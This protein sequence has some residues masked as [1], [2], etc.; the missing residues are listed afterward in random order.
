MSRRQGAVSE[1]RRVSFDRVDPRGGGR[2]GVE[3]TK[4]CN[5]CDEWEPVME[6]LIKIKYFSGLNNFSA[7]AMWGLE[8]GQ[9][10]IEYD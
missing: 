10:P 5:G 3:M 1:C 8:S 6:H 7:V 2:W 4:N 9:L